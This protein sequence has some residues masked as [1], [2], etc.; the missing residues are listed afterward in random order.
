MKVLVALSTAV[1]L[2]AMIAGA[3]LASPDAASNHDAASTVSAA[4]HQSVPLASQ[5]ISG[6]SFNGAG[7]RM[8]QSCAAAG[9][10]CKTGTDEPGGL[11]VSFQRPCCPGTQC[12]LT[13]KQQTVPYWTYHYTCGKP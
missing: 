4:V 12:Q 5:P 2:G 7:V 11:R 1:A 6:D 10:P 13:Q 8:A 3:G 9:Q